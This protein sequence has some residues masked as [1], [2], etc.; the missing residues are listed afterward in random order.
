M[1]GIARRHML[2]DVSQDEEWKVVFHDLPRMISNGHSQ[3]VLLS[4]REMG[5][6]RMQSDYR[7]KI[8]RNNEILQNLAAV[9]NQPELKSL[10]DRVANFVRKK[11]RYR[12]EQEWS[13][14]MLRINLEEENQNFREIVKQE[15][16]YLHNLQSYLFMYSEVAEVRQLME[17]RIDELL[18]KNLAVD[19]RSTKIAFQDYCRDL[20]HFSR[21]GGGAVD[22]GTYRFNTDPFITVSQVEIDHLFA[23]GL[24]KESEKFV[25]RN[26]LTFAGIAV[27]QRLS[28]VKPHQFMAA[29]M[30]KDE[31]LVP[32]I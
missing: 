31:D 19:P 5:F 1:L 12:T 21:F 17:K 30:Y 4:G 16:K 18:A 24:I 32:S 13:K 25:P 22:D 9:Q 28:E 8:K 11:I 3:R 20:L 10:F 27:L 26:N 6:S 2:G 15:E 14:E 7:E 29:K 23:A